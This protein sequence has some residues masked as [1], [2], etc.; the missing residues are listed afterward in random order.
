M[1]ESM[2]INV[3][4]FWAV[5]EAYE[6]GRTQ[7]EL[8]AAAEEVFARLGTGRQTMDMVLWGASGSATPEFRIPDPQTPI[9]PGDLLLYSLEVAGPGGH[10]VEFSRPLTRGAVGADI[11][12]RGLVFGSGG[13]LLA[14]PNLERMERAIA[15]PLARASGLRDRLWSGT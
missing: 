3:A 11:G 8:M 7:A 1:R 4:G 13:E 9:A 6:P 14:T 5:H 2:A 10:W 15:R 12:Q